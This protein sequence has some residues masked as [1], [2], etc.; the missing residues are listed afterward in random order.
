M[1]EVVEVK[2]ISGHPPT[3]QA[4]AA[5]EKTRSKLNELRATLEDRAQSIRREKEV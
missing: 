3:A 4:L 1:I 5:I 2:N